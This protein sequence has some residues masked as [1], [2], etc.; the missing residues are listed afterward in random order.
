[1][2]GRKTGRKRRLIK[3]GNDLATDYP[4]IAKE[5]HPTK[6]G[7]LTPSDILSSSGTKVWLLCLHCNEGNQ[8]TP[9][10]RIK[11][12]ECTNDAC[13]KRNKL[14]ILKKL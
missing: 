4:E 12:R 13:R 7:E 11:G 3:G 1:M 14:K 10:H 8:I 9:S 2:T 6:N 5:W